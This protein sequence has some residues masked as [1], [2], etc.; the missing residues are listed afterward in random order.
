MIAVAL[1]A[2]A[3]TGC[4]SND[5]QAETTTVITETALNTQAPITDAAETTSAETEPAET[6]MSQ[7]E[8]VS[9]VTQMSE[10]VMGNYSKVTANRLYDEKPMTM[11]IMGGSPFFNIRVKSAEM[12]P[13]VVFEMCPVYLEALEQVGLPSG[14]I[15]VSAYEKDDKGIIDETMTAWRSDNGII[16]ALAYAPGGEKVNDCTV[17]MLYEYFGDR[18]TPL[19]AEETADIIKMRLEKKA[20]GLFHED[21]MALL[22]STVGG[23]IAVTVRT[24]EE[25]LLPAA[26]EYAYEVIMPIAEKSELPFSRINAMVYDNDE[27]G[28]IVQETMVGWTTSDGE[29]GTFNSKIEAISDLP[30]TI[31]ELYD[32]YGE[33]DELIEKAKNDER[34]ERP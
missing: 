34:I 7:D 30:M 33:Y 3:F 15:S 19:T 27:K 6:T 5:N 12:I 18:I 32:K 10:L 9:K 2:A 26:A 1:L 16:G 20:Q 4:S 17:N 14:S 13:D 22:V 25:F 21:K 23:S 29:T 28:G 31:G 8:M 11:G 24:Y